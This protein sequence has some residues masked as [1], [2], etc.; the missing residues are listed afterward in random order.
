MTET[1]I[2]YNDQIIPDRNAKISPFTRG[3]HY[4]DGVFE[5][6]RS[7]KGKVFYFHEHAKRLKRGLEIL[8]IK[9]AWDDAE[10]LYATKKLLEAN[11]LSDSAIKI[12][13][14]RQGATGPTPDLNAS[15]DMLITTCRFDHDKKTRYEQ[16]IRGHVVSMKRNPLS[17]VVFI[18]SLNYLDNIM[19][20][21]EAEQNS[22]DE[23][24][25]LNIHGRIAE[26]ATSNIF[27]VS[28]GVIF[29]PPVH[30]GILNGIT[31]QAILE[32][33]TNT[34]I[35]CVE[36]ELMPEEL[37][38]SDEAFLTNSLMEIMPLISVN[39]KNIGDGNPGPITKKMIA[40]YKNIVFKNLNGQ[41]T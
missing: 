36:K 10:I 37:T 35:K 24:L 6:M 33:A 13:A 1:Y 27:I 5:T 2:F 11:N 28:N 8:Q 21:V 40:E 3:L 12:L 39:N 14:F 25:F 32:I 31:R 41:K 29:T 18:K 16:G 30:E 26:G 20:R 38:T 15:A 34:G 23:A 17:P 9:S 7:Y 4:G 19:G 22:S